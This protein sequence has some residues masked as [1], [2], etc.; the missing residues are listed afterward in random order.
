VNV[1]A[2]IF[3]GGE[4]YWLNPVEREAIRRALSIVGHE[5][6]GRTMDT[7][8]REALRREWAE[9][10]IGFGELMEL[11][12]RLDEASG[13]SRLR[14]ARYQLIAARL[15]EERGR[16]TADVSPPR[17]TV[18]TRAANPKRS[19]AIGTPTQ[20]P[21]EMHAAEGESEFGGDAAT[22]RPT[23]RLAGAPSDHRIGFRRF[24]PN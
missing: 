18:L 8:E 17:A 15:A 11:A 14:R 19:L 20:A 6:Q 5:L 3:G 24:A 23:A 16:Q 4:P 2:E 21:S 12:G 9:A 22:R 10:G 7:H 13:E 1:H